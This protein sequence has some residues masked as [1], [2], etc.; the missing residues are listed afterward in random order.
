MAP[1]RDL[2]GIGLATEAKGG[3]LGNHTLSVNAHRQSHPGHLASDRLSVRADGSDAPFSDRQSGA[4]DRHLRRRHRGIRRGIFVHLEAVSRLNQT[5]ELLSTAAGVGDEI[6]GG[7]ENLGGT[8]AQRAARLDH[9]NAA[10]EGP[11]RPAPWAVLVPLRG[12]P[13]KFEENL[14]KVFSYRMHK[15]QDQIQTSQFQGSGDDL[16]DQCR[17]VVLVRVPDFLDQA[18]NAKLLE[19]T[20]NLARVLAWHHRSQMLVLDAVSCEQ[21]QVTSV[22][23]IEAAVR[24]PAMFTDSSRDLQQVFQALSTIAIAKTNSRYRWLAAAM[25]FAQDR[26]AVDGFLH[27]RD[28]HRPA[29]ILGAAGARRIRSHFSLY[30]GELHATE[31]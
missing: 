30:S 6:A 5:E 11:Y 10:R 18:V 9:D 8:L 24:V 17:E 28:L 26:R 2:P 27:R 1:S 15:C 23:E 22:E 16:R 13:A 3:L 14:R 19:Q 21:G 29:T 20:T 31:T 12:G 7:A 25:S 4:K